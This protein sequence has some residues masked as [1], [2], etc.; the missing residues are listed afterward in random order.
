MRA[1]AVD[2]TGVLTLTPE[3]EEDRQFL[4]NL[5]FAGVGWMQ[6][7][8]RLPENPVLVLA[9]APDPFGPGAGVGA[10]NPG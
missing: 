6:L 2:A 3:T 8:G 4:H 10:D 9:R 5:K 7:A 1:L